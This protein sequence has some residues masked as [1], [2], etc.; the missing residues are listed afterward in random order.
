VNELVPPAEGASSNEP[1]AARPEGVQNS[2]RRG[3]GCPR[4]DKGKDII[5]ASDQGKS[6][7]TYNSSDERVAE[8][9]ALSL[10]D[11]T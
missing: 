1:N 10:S 2:A 11:A 7:P 9:I 5:N 3:R 8:A 6:I 4:N